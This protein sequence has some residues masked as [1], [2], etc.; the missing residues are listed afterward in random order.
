M[1]LCAP[2]L[3]RTAAL[4]C[5]A[6]AR[7]KKVASSCFSAAAHPLGSAKD[8]SSMSFRTFLSAAASSASAARSSLI[9]RCAW[10][11]ANERA[12]MSSTRKSSTR[13]KFKIMPYVKRN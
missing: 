12:S 9:P 4:T 1:A 6:A 10:N 3:L 7:A 5:F 8:S 11:S 13:I 2:L